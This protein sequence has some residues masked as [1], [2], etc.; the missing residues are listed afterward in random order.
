MVRPLRLAPLSRLGYEL[1]IAGAYVEAEALLREAL[2]EAERAF[3]PDDIRLTEH[4]NML[5]V[6]LRFA[7][8]YA[9][10]RTA[11]QRA[12]EIFEAM[13]VEPTAT[14]FH[15]LSGLASAT[16]DYVSGETDARKAIEIRRSAGAAG[17][18]IG[19][20]L[21]GL[22]DALAGQRRFAEAEAAY[23]EALGLYSRDGWGMHPE[24]AYALHGLGDTLADGGR[25]E[26][27]EAVYRESIAI[28][29]A[30]LGEHHH[31]VAATY[32]NLAAVLVD[33]GRDKDAVEA[34][35]RALKIVREVLPPSHPIREGCEAL[36]RSITEMQNNS[37]G[38]H[39]GR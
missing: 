12:G 17:F 14:H 23:R 3:G 21:C 11:Y 1:S 31:E 13:K 26:A 36:A 37:A 18:V 35:A 15:N 29:V 27:A 8:Q 24:Y 5:A 32:N 33:L 4:H 7:G 30:A 2:V 34:S 25:W 20:D 6:C 10:A 22:A 19:S 9:E 28:K 38:R 16:G 39:V